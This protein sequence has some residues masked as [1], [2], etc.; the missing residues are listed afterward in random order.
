MMEGIQG[1][2]S[3]GS[4]FI[5]Y[6]FERGLESLLKGNFVIRENIFAKGLRLR[7]SRRWE[8]AAVDRSSNMK[9][10]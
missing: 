2:Q 10:A 5:D 9:L 6:S 7:G 8:G 3:E 4:G 1:V